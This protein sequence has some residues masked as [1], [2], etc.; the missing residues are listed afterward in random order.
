[1]LLRSKGIKPLASR[2]RIEHDWRW[3]K[4]TPDLADAAISHL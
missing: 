3:R 4:D 1:M 2:R